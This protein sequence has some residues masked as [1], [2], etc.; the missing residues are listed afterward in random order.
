MEELKGI[1]SAIRL[2]SITVSISALTI[3]LAILT[4]NRR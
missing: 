1:E 2:L 4:V 3:I